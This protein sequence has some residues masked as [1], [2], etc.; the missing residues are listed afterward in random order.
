[1]P[2]TWKW[3]LEYFGKMALSYM[4]SEDSF[5]ICNVGRRRSGKTVWSLV[6]ARFIDPDFNEDK[7]AFAPE[8]F[9]QLLKEYKDSALLFDEAGTG[10]YSRDA[11]KRLNKSIIKSLQIFG[12][13][14]LTLILNLPHIEMIDKDIREKNI[15]DIVFNLESRFDRDFS[16]KDMTIDQ[17]R[18]F[19][20][21]KGNL[22]KRYTAEPFAFVGD[23][24]RSGSLMPYQ[25]MVN[26][27]SYRI[28]KVRLGDMKEMFEYAKVDW[29]LW[30]AYQKKKIEYYEERDLNDDSTDS[31]DGR[32][33]RHA[34][35]W[36]KDRDTLIKYLHSQGMSIYDIAK[37]LNRSPNTIA[38]ALKS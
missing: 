9:D 4:A 2:F 26:G 34:K 24:F 29:K 36:K 8:E 3:L 30:K 35:D 22:P 20:K 27:K 19:I 21:E 31:V 38:L 12:F 15:L 23:S 16:L 25:A 11:M 33:T 7:I 10:L 32:T 13:R 18:Y 37:L 1:M 28:G 14:R 17:L 6:M 5:S